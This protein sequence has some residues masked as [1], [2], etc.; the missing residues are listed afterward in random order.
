[1]IVH[2]LSSFWHF[3]VS[4]VDSSSRVFSHGSYHWLLIFT[5]C[6]SH[7][8]EVCV[9]EVSRLHSGESQEDNQAK[10]STHIHYTSGGYTSVRE[11]MCPRGLPE[12]SS[13]R[14]PFQ[15]GTAAQYCKFFWFF[16]ATRNSFFFLF[17]F[18]IQL[19]QDFCMLVNLFFRTLR[20]KQNKSKF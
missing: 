17:L 12:R 5:L 11:S 19:S 9:T 18:F 8:S 15:K 1:M 20:T 14:M 6:S 7:T 3:W 13:S 10:S 4:F 2:R 16:K